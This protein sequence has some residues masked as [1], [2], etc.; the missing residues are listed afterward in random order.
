MEVAPAESSLEAISAVSMVK[1][2]VLPRATDVPEMLF[3]DLMPRQVKELTARFTDA[4][5]SLLSTTEAEATNVTNEGRALL[6]SVGLPGAL[7]AYKT[8]GGIPDNLWNKIQHVQEAGAFPALQNRYEEL[9]AFANRAHQTIA[10]IEA[11]L[12]REEAS[13]D[14]FRRRN[15]RWD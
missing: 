9:N 6:S 10:D 15:V 7:E 2:T 8:G 12:Q 11:S 3:A 14:D 4:A 1:P 5:Y 13:D